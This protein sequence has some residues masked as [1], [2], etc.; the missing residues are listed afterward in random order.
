MDLRDKL[1]YLIGVKYDE[2]HNIISSD[3][4]ISILLDYNQDKILDW[5]RDY[6]WNEL[7]NPGLMQCFYIQA[8]AQVFLD[9]N[10][11]IS[12]RAK[13]GF[14]QFIELDYWAEENEERATEMQ[15]LKK[16]IEEN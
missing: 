9:Y 5:L 8:T 12:E 3:I 13:K 16:A 2:D 4:D 6:N 11:K 10:V 1:F 15:K 14:Y 7:Y